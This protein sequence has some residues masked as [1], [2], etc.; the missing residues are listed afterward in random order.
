V[1]TRRESAA[2]KLTVLRCVEVVNNKKFCVTFWPECS[3]FHIL[4]AL[5]FQKEIHSDKPPS[6]KGN[7]VERLPV[8]SQG[9]VVWS[10]VLWVV[11][12][13]GRQRL[14]TFWNWP[15]DDHA[16]LL[17]RYVENIQCGVAGWMGQ[18]NTSVIPTCVLTM[19]N[20]IFMCYWSCAFYWL[21]VLLNVGL[22]NPWHFSRVHWGHSCG[23]LWHTQQCAV[24]LL[25]CVCLFNSFQFSHPLVLLLQY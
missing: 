9:N 25:S 11:W 22:F 16:V 13:N 2:S 18:K 6:L 19:Y 1:N 3:L 23:Q 14:V 12:L 5:S 21:V 24:A 7:L 15:S 10:A 20:V 17:L 8:S 4:N